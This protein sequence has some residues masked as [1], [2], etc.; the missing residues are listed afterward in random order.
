M[1]RQSTTNILSIGQINPDD[2]RFFKVTDS[3]YAFSL[4]FHLLMVP[5]MFALGADRV[6]EYNIISVLIVAACIILNRKGWHSTAFVIFFGDI[7]IHAYIATYY[8][9]WDAGFF[10]Y[11]LLLAPLTFLNS[12]WSLRLKIF[13]CVVLMISFSN[14]FNGYHEQLYGQILIDPRFGHYL[15]YVNTITTII[16]Y[17][18]I[19]YY[20]SKAANDSEQKLR[21]AHME[22]EWIA[23]TDALTHISNRRAMTKAIEQEISRSRRKNSTFIVALGDIDNFKALNDNYS[24]EYGDSVLVQVASLIEQNI[25][26]HDRVA[27]WGGE[28]FMILLPDTNASDGLN[29]I[30]RLRLKIATTTHIYK[31]REYPGI[32][33]TFGLCQFNNNGNINDCVH[34]ADRAMYRGKHQGKNCTIVSDTFDFYAQASPQSES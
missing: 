1:A 13:A 19:G 7:N 8:L 33:M 29:L 20:Y 16:L 2:Y 27:R 31:G 25:R 30:E 9:G 17:S 11:I 10:H 23:H 21:T 34:H 12:C 28:E 3:L 4:I 24:H 18:A 26:E 32:T 15:L 14:L 5:L 22:A 6:A